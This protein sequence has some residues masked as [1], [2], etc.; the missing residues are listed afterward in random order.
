M[1]A[2]VRQNEKTWQWLRILLGIFLLL[3]GGIFFAKWA[4]DRQDRWMREDLLNQ[5]R[6]LAQTLN[7]DRLRSLQ[8]HPEDETRQEY[9][10]LKT[11]LIASRQMNPDW[12]FIYLMD[13]TP[14]GAVIFLLDSEILDS[15]DASPPG[16]VY[17]E[18]SPDLQRAFE[19]RESVVEGPLPDRWGIWVSAF[20]PLKDLKS[21]ELVAVLGIDMDAQRWGQARLQA[22]G[23]PIGSMLALIL[24]WLLGN[25]LLGRRTHSGAC[26]TFLCWHLESILL[27]LTGFTL[28]LTAVW[29]V[30][31]REERNRQIFF[32]HLA[33]IEAAPPLSSI[34]TLQD[35]AL[36]GFGAFIES[37]QEVT[38]EEF[39]QYTRH[40]TDLSEVMFWNWVEVVPGKDRKRFEADTAR[41]LHTRN[42]EIWEI[43]EK[44][45]RVHSPEK[46]WYYPLVYAFPEKHAQAASGFDIGSN[47]KSRSVLTIL[48]RTHLPT[49]SAP[50]PFLLPQEEG[51]GI[52]LLRPV[53]DSADPDRLI[54]IVTAGLQIQKWLQSGQDMDPDRLLLAALD[55][56]QLY[57]DKAPIQIGCTDPIEKIHPHGFQNLPQ[58][59]VIQ[60]LL[61][62]GNTYALVAHPTADFMAIHP[63]HGIWLISL[64]GIALTVSLAWI[65]GLFVH[66]RE[67]L[68]QLVDSQNRELATAMHH[69]DLLAKQNHILTWEVDINGLYMDISDTVKD[70]LGYTP[71]ELIG[72]KHFYDLCLKKDAMRFKELGIALMAKGHAIRD[73]VYPIQTKTGKTVWLASNGIPIRNAQGVLQGYWGTG[74]DITNRKRTEKTLIELVQAKQDAADRYAA[75]ISASNT[76]AWEYNDSTGQL[77]CSP[78]YFSML[79]Y[80]EKDLEPSP[81]KGNI[82]AFWLNLMHPDDRPRAR[83]KLTT[84]LKIP[85]GMYEQTFRLKHRDGYW[86]WI[87]SRGKVIRDAAGKPTNMMVGTH[88]DITAT[89]QAEEA[90]RA[91]EKQYRM[92]TENMKDVVWTVDAESLRFLYL[93]PTVE[94]MVGYTAEELKAKTLDAAMPPEMRKE[95]TQRL[96]DRVSEVRAGSISSDTFFTSEIPMVH[97]NGTPI[98]TEL[99]TR[100]W[101]N[102]RTGR[103]ELHAVVRDI[104]E[105]KHVEIEL[106]ESQRRYAALM[107]NL[108]GMAYRCRN[109][110]NWTMEF[111][112]Q[113]GGELTG[114]APEDLLENKTSPHLRG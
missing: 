114:Y 66:R 89:K 26:K 18:A 39:N 16:Q 42:Y 32:Q 87:W 44:G 88:I 94:R 4:A 51:K 5:T 24:I 23:A 90:L 103:V 6:L 112:S 36:E 65:L 22:M 99:V 21:N 53:F 35:F 50:I 72:K 20:V 108:P 19:T 61:I 40:L 48:S 111:V 82:E 104:T 8:A 85:E 93:S 55:L 59:S 17:E 13:R 38:R 79:G 54:G 37:S 31:Q 3:V 98:I 106:K 45:E 15:P 101:L 113:G 97:K 52:L 105:R 92:L 60:P 33:Q 75:L 41:R 70:T 83:S 84:Y 27:L 67:R 34:H 64:A 86:V 28:T 43:N 102:N 14:E 62:F 57:P 63:H 68:T 56:F 73:L 12:R 25:L 30:H 71:K 49:A 91:S 1:K 96:R 10:Q 109:D 46:D 76:G 95:L 74:T 29:L 69:Y 81:E 110:R 2:P 77:W 107:A 58:G 9:Q 11:Q 100:Y 47:P 80:Q 7:L 78:E